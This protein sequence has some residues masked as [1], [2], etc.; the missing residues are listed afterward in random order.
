M[1]DFVRHVPCPDCNSRDNRA[2]YDDGHEWC[3]GCGGYTPPQA[4]SIEEM[5]QH[6]RQHETNNG[7]HKSDNHI[8]LPGD[9]SRILSPVAVKWLQ[10][11]DLTTNEIYGSGNF[12]WSEERDSLIYSV[13]DSSGNVLMYQERY[14]GA[15]PTRVR[16]ITKGF[17]EDVFHFIGNNA[18][19]VTLVEDIVSA[20]KVGR[21]TTAL[22]LWGSNISQHRIA[23]LC[24]M[25]KTINIWLDNDKKLYATSARQRAAP[26]FHRAYI[27]MSTFDPKVYD[28][29]QIKQ[30]LKG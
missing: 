6:L 25:F 23:R 28:D 14:M 1:S 7:D 4:A 29:E 11:Y 8:D 30:F 13:F 22:P 16:F 10:K 20:I 27:T 3:F 15:S 18:N 26:F 17:P 12:F 5:A 21:H 9:C 19:S 24:K 2:V